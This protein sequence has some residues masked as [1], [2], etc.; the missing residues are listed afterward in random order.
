LNYK[1]LCISILLIISSASYGQVGIGNS[2]P[3]NSAM[4]DIV[5]TNKGVIIPRIELTGSKDR[6]TI[7]NGNVESLL[8][9]NT[10]MV[11][12][13]K[14]GYYYWSNNKWNKI[15]ITDD[16]LLMTADSGLTVAN[17]KLG[18][19]GALERPTE[20]ATTAMNTF[21]IKGLGAGDLKTDELVV[22]DKTTEILK[23]VAISSLVQEKQKVVIAQNG[24]TEFTSSLPILDPEK[25]NVYRNGIRIGFD[26]IDRTV[27]KLESGVVCY[28]NDEIRIVQFY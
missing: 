8:I 1:F 20:I 13:V 26:V 14:P 21:A 17:G 11:L 16:N 25:I 12:D 7:A 18:L 2:N 15:A 6:T 10:A 5:S 4:L 27:I 3:N 22:V 19:G 23:K 24:Q 9:Y 28:Q